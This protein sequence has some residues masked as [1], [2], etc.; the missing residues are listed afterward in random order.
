MWPEIQKLYGHGYE[1][2]CL[3]ATADGTLLASACKSTNPEYAAILL[4]HVFAIFKLI[5]LTY[6]LIFIG[7][8]QIGEILKNFFL[9]L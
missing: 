6:Y 3:A 4:W 1:V 9:T 2:Y 7:I 8:L 5:L